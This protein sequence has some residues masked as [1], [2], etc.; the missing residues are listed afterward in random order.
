MEFIK[1]DNKQI[2]IYR[3]SD[4]T[5]Q[6]WVRENLKE[7]NS[8]A[9]KRVFYFTPNEL[10]DLEIEFDEFD[11]PFPPIAFVFAE[12][13]NDYYQINRHVI[14]T[15]KNFFFHKDIDIL[16]EYFIAETKISILKQID[17]LVNEDIYV[18]GNAQS[19]MP[20]QA[21]VKMIDE[22]PTTYEK[23]VYAEARVSSIIKNY[24]DTTR[25]AEFKLQNY[26]NKKSSKKGKNLAKVFQEYE[27]Q[28]FHTIQ[29]KLKGMLESENGYNEDQWQNEILEIILLLYPKYICTFKTV[30]LKIN[31]RQR[32]FLDFM[33]V[34]SNGNIDVIEIKKP[35]ENSIMTHS[36]YREN[37]T[38]HKDLI[39]TIMQL[40]KYLFHLN[41]YGEVSEKRL[42][43]KYRD[44][45]PDGLKIKITSP[46]GFIIMGRETNLNNEQKSDFEIVKRKYKNVID[47]ITYDDL[48]QR[49]DF[50]IEQIQKI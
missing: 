20:L 46:K 41:R 18:D 32:R 6:D 4:Y 47:I 30:H 50:T 21:Y 48:L 33:L 9:F 13:T 42:N 38:P 45:L 14:G 12:L 37:Y 24:F 3:Y 27:L 7:H 17:D 5:N 23:K 40:E 10:Y 15:K 34:D 44:K 35:F 28:K 36:L 19:N 2:F 31:D 11:E 25:D 22:F 39:G 26:L 43:E 29:D 8:V 49:L 16:L 1:V